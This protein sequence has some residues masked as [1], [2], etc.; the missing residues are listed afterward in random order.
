MKIA[1]MTETTLPAEA[2]YVVI[3]SRTQWIDRRVLSGPAPDTA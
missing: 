3:G 1:D 2:D